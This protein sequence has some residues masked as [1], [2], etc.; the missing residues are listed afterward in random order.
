M[1]RKNWPLLLKNYLI[2]DSHETFFLS[3][4]KKIFPFSRNITCYLENAILNMDK[5][6]HLNFYEIVKWIENFFNTSR[7]KLLYNI[8]KKFNGCCVIFLNNSVRMI[9]FHAKI[10]KRAFVNVFEFIYSTKNVKKNL[11]YHFEKIKNIFVKNVFN[12]LPG[13]KRKIKLD[14]LFSFSIKEFKKKKCIFS[15]LCSSH[16]YFKDLEM[17]FYS[18]CSFKCQIRESRQIYSSYLSENQNLIN[19]HDLIDSEWL[20]FSKKMDFYLKKVTMPVEI[21]AVSFRRVVIKFSSINSVCYGA[22]LKTRG[23][24]RTE[25]T[26]KKN[27][28]VI[29]IT[30]KGELVAL[31]IYKP[32]LINFKDKV[33]FVIKKIVMSKNI[34]PKSW[35]MGIFSTKKKLLFSSGFLFK[36]K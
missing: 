29:I 36:K 19:F 27:Q 2:M 7:V 1:E 35:K 15:S 6:N 25:D 4:K 24:V 28:E 21:A 34:Y 13:I 20:Y 3:D 14:K 8:T 10:Q 32:S 17:Y 16:V 23:V 22:A 18:T 11:L 30:L 31:G 12:F 26:I 9:D 33:C 5:P